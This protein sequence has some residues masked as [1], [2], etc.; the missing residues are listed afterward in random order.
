MLFVEQVPI[1]YLLNRSE[2]ILHIEKLTRDEVYFKADRPIE[3]VTVKEKITLMFDYKNIVIVFTVEVKTM[4]IKTA[5]F[6]ATMP[7][8]LYKNLERSYSRVS[9]P[10]DIQIQFAFVEDRYFLP[11]HKIVGRES[12]DSGDLLPNLDSSNFNDIMAHLGSWIQEYVDD[13]KLVLFKDANLQSLEEQVVAATGKT[14]YL[15]SMQDQFPALGDDPKNI[16]INEAI[17]NQHLKH[18]NPNTANDVMVQFLKDK[19]S[20]G[21]LSDAWVPMLFQ[22][23]TIGYIHIW[24]QKEG[25]PPFD[26]K[27]IETLYKYMSSLVHA[28]QESGYFESCRLKDKFIKVTAMDISASG[29]RFAF[30]HLPISS[31]LRPDS[32]ISL[33]LI[34]SKRTIHIGAKIVR[35]YKEKN[36]DFFGCRFLDITPE[37]MRF[38]FE[39]IYGKS[40]TEAE[41]SLIL[42][43]V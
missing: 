17:F 39:Y 27:L 13:Y 5:H 22:G 34:T 21:I 26:Y 10:D 12:E 41:T 16:L 9:I 32:K 14:L 15:P 1:M 24:I 30:P 20:T 11:F 3:G 4:D 19:Q 37:D 25:K 28:L 35:Q 36:M 31:F 42:G 33:K 38:L 7:D 18:T 23:Y 43:Q 29:L 8:V 40:I 2:Y 6:I